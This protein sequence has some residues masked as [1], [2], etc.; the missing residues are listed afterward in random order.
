MRTI[1]KFGGGHYI[2]L[3]LGYLVNL[4]LWEIAYI[5]CGDITA[6]EYTGDAAVTHPLT[7]RYPA[8]LGIIIVLVIIKESAYVYTSSKLAA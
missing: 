4:S 5:I 6:P 8:F 7:L 3:T 1:N 2:S